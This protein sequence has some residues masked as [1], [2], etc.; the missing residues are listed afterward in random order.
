MSVIT[1]DATEDM[2]RKVKLLTQSVILLQVQVEE[3]A[4][5]MSYITRRRWW[6]V[7]KWLS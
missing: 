5:A 4:R 6:Q 7:W 2:G 3:L 1:K